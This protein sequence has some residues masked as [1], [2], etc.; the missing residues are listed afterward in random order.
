[1]KY[2]GQIPFLTGELL[3]QLIGSL[4]HE[5]DNATVFGPTT[6]QRGAFAGRT[7]GRAARVAPVYPLTLVY[8]PRRSGVGTA[9]AHGTTS[10]PFQPQSFF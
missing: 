8:L 7:S 1:M 9:A 10:A 2:P 4:R 6:D 3:L 5:V